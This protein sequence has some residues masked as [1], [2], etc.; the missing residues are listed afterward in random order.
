IVRIQ[1][2]NIRSIASYAASVDSL[3]RAV[4]VEMLDRA[5]AD[6]A[7]PLD[8]LV[9]VSL[10][11]DPHR[12]GAPVAELP[13]LADRVEA[14][15]DLRLAWLMAVAPPGA[16]AERGYADLAG[17]AAQLRAGHPRAKTLS[18]GM[19]GDLEAAVG[20]GATQVRVGTALLGGRPPVVG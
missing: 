8:V 1:R 13:A 20:H 16:D 5:A 15:P 10:D 3:D 12:G 11:G 2:N 4:L 14:A 18:A 9:Q 6:R 19:S 7:E 17:Y